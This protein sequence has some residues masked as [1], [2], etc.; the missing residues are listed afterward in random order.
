MENEVNSD[1][2]KNHILKV[3]DIK[4]EKTDEYKKLQEYKSLKKSSE[5]K[6]YYKFKNSEK[7]KIFNELNDSQ[8]ISDYESLEAYINSDEFK[9]EKKYLLTKDKFKLSD[10]F[11]QAEEYKKLK[12][13]EKILWYQKL[14][15]KND[16]DKLH[17]WNLSFEENFEENKLNDEKWMSGYYWGKN[18]LNDD[19]VQVNEKQFFK[20]SN[21]E[22]GN[23][24]LKIITKSEEAKG[25]VWDPAQGFYEK[26]FSYTSGLINTGQHFRQQYGLFKAKIKVNH[27]YPV[28][29][30][31]W[32]RGEKITP[33]IDIFK[34]CK[35]SPS[36]LEIAN[37]WNVDGT[38]KQNKKALGGLNFSKDYFIYSLEW[39]PEKL[40]WKINDVVLYEQTE[41][42][43]Q[44]PMYIVLSS[45]I[46]QETPFNGQ[47]SM[48]IDWVR[49]Y[50]K[51][52]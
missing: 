20:E 47:A 16:F 40:T 48:E 28:H 26:H 39:T 46:A 6:Q 11:K 52:E 1:E 37:Y 4:F 18:L 29:H 13:S 8:E 41:G 7:L 2:F 35:K 12:K 10:E 23:S 22:I 15:K 31:F 24:N 34:Y 32:L 30:A 9:E 50:V 44:E 14:E 49:A 25:K 5:I 42:V 3:K 21:L 45:G 17:V 38:I 33:E 19:Y 51:N 36:K 43:P 27:S